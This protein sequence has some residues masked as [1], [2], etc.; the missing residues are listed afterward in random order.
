[1]QRVSPGSGAEKRS[2]SC[3]VGDKWDG[4]DNSI[5][6]GGIFCGGRFRNLLEKKTTSTNGKRGLGEL[7]GWR[8][9]EEV[10]S[11]DNT[12]RRRRS[13]ERHKKH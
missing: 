5:D 12:W 13:E 2:G 4:K 7:E 9:R 6:S 11:L 8:I 10:K 1:M 3:M